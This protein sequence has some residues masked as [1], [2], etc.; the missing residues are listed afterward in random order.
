MPNVMTLVRLL[1]ATG[2]IIVGSIDAT[3]VSW[4]VVETTELGAIAVTGSGPRSVGMLAPRTAQT[5]TDE[6]LDEPLDPEEELDGPVQR[7]E[8]AT[9]DEPLDGPLL[10]EEPAPVTDETDDSIAVDVEPLDAPLEAE[11]VDQPDVETEILD[12]PLIDETVAVVP[13]AEPVAAAV[14]V[15]KKVVSEPVAS[16]GKLVTSVRKKGVVPD[17]VVVVS[18]RQPLP[19]SLNECDVAV[20]SGRS[21]VGSD[22]GIVPVVAGHQPAIPR[23]PGSAA[24]IS[25]ENPSVITSRR[26]G[27]QIGE[28]PEPDLGDSI[29]TTVRAAIFPEDVIVPE[30]LIVPGEVTVAGNT[31]REDPIVLWRS[32]LEAAAL[33]TGIP[34]EMLATV[35]RATSNGNP[36]AESPTGGVGLMHVP[37]GELLARGI[38]EDQWRDPATNIR[39]GAQLMAAGVSPAEVRSGAAVTQYLAD[40]CGVEDV[41][42]QNISEQVDE[43]IV[44]YRLR[45]TTDGA[46]PQ[47]SPAEIMDEI[48]WPFAEEVDE[49]A[50]DPLARVPGGEEANGVPTR[51]PHPN[52][53]GPDEQP[54]EWNWPWSPAG[55]E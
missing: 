50:A 29:A 31:S 23:V 12:A 52:A 2:P 40:S 42:S 15:A 20:G 11:V 32:E 9:G 49:T 27:V 37:T 55:D 22:C 30:V 46:Q 7:T 35:I 6:P 14:P 13:V 38:R 51:S 18:G 21:T 33:E 4:P 41:C 10:E 45:A 36:L 5:D 24:L 34:V 48:G 1:L 17:R 28:Y 47:A 53:P 8:D 39:I 43:W 16:K 19:S 3:T 54:W 26:D 44:Y 25:T